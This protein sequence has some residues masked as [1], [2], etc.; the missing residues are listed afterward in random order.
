VLRPAAADPSTP[1]LLVT[2]GPRDEVDRLRK[3][4]EAGGVPVL[5]GPERGAAA[6]R[7]LIA[8]A[9]DA[10]VTVLRSVGALLLAHPEIA[11][12]D[13]NPLR[14]TGDGLVAADALVVLAGAGRGEHRRGP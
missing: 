9:R 4:V 12:L 1:L 7:A 6:M 11:E 14:A 8:D 2:G 13:V 3:V 10:L 5:T